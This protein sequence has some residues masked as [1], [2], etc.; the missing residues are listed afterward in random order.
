MAKTVVG[1]FDNP[2]EAERVIQNLV[3]SGFSR[4]DIS[5]V[6]N[7]ADNRYD[8]DLNDTGDTTGH[9]VAQ[10]A[11]KGA[12]GG[13]IA[14]GIAGLLAGLGLVAIPGIGPV[15]AAGWIGT[16]LAGAGIGAVAGGLIGSLVSLGIPEEQA[17]FYA[18]GI[19]RGGSLVI[20]RAA[21]DRAEYAVDI[22]RDNGAVD[23]DKRHEDY[24]ITGF[25]KFDDTAPAYTADEVVAER[26]LYSTPVT[27]TAGRTPN[28]GNETRIPIVEEQIEVDKRAVVNGGARVYT[29]VTERT[30]RD[31]VPPSEEHVDVNRR[32]LANDTARHTDIDVV[33][34]Q[35]L[36]EGATL[37]E[38][39]NFDT[40]DRDVK[41]N[42]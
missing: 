32:V 27:A 14:G 6:A 38:D 36:N 39:R 22:L 20:V 12:E 1:L 3:D 24:Q 37:A 23:V 4:D 7:N 8:F 34:V 41:V 18:E 25:S 31:D 16:T 19:R 28:A 13:A 30:V 2:T 26:D 33:D 40:V 29:H 5:L 10:E 9:P 17:H 11:G 42:R 35:E 21:D 15:L